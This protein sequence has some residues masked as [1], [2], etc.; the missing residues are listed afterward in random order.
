MDVWYLKIP[1]ERIGVLIGKDGSVKR[2]IEEITGT[3]LHVDSSTGEVNIDVNGA[4]PVMALK[5]R[6]IV[7]AIGRG[8]SP[9]RALTL[10]GDDVYFDLIDIRDY[11]GKS[12][13]RVKQMRGRIIGQ[14]GK[15]RRLIE[16]YTEAQVSVYGNT[17]AII[18]PLWS[19]EAARQAIRMLLQGCEHGTVYKFLEKKRKE[20]KMER[21]REFMSGR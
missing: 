9:D 21:F 15:T 2:R 16:Q 12:P 4:D 11:V 20:L 3:K 8:F 10:T 5:V 19:L 1:K 17:I 14:K 13:N 18:G 7:K 6:D